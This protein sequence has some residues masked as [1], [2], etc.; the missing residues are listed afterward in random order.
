MDYEQENVDT[1]TPC[2]FISTM[3]QLK[4]VLPALLAMLFLG[5]ALYLVF[6]FYQYYLDPDAVAY[7]TLAK[8]YAAGQYT[9]AVNGYW[10]PWA[11]WLTAFC[12]GQNMA[13]FAAAIFVNALAGFGFLWASQ[14]LFRTFNIS[15]TAQYVLQFNLV[16]FLVYAVFW[17]SFDDLWACFFLLLV[18]RLLLHRE[19]LEKPLLWVLT[20]MLGALAY[21]SKSYSLPFF[22]LEILVTGYYLNR[23]FDRKYRWLKMAGVTIL[24]MLAFSFPWL[25]ALHEKYGF[26]STGSAGALNLSWYLTGHPYWK[27]GISILLPPVY[28]D[29]PSYW[30]DPFVVNGA[31]PYFWHTPKL[32]LLQLIRI[33]Y[34]FLQLIQSFNELSAF[35]L[36]LFL[37][38]IAIVFYPP[39]RQRADRQLVVLCL[40]MV[41]FPLGYILINFESRYL[42]YLLPPGMVIGAILLD[43]LIE[44][45]QPGKATILLLWLVFAVTF[46]V[47]P[48]LGLKTMYRVGTPEYRQAAQLKAAGVQGSFTSNIPSGPETQQLLRLAYFSGNPYYTLPFPATRQELL[49]DMRR[50]KVRYYFHFYT[51]GWDDFQLYDEQGQ[52]FEEVAPG[53]VAGIKV[54]LVK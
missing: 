11:V 45:W 28:P 9:V 36:L 34:H 26:W 7:L 52:A 23:S 32:F 33:G 3:Q 40:S 29:S 18:L 43:K 46:L 5:M 12:I 20:G 6:P 2:F 49:Q 39:I 41:L 25:Y 13:P 19:F 14:L 21:L 42:W 38:A 27:E 8:R 31:L 10:S 16:F 50:Y 37:S 53:K 22:V 4:N 44:K 47:Q 15:R 54:F 24:T 30:E 35:F 51:A 48:M 17:Q 1:T